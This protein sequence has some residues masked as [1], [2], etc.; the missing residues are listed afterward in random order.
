M[1]SIP[2]KQQGRNVRRADL[3]GTLTHLMQATH[4]RVRCGSGGD[5]CKAVVRVNDCPVAVIDCMP[6]ESQE[7][8][9]VYPGTS[10]SPCVNNKDDVAIVNRRSDPF[11]SDVDFELVLV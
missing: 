5:G 3:F 1:L 10:S 8:P 2:F 4:I 11:T 9:L 7:L 6:G